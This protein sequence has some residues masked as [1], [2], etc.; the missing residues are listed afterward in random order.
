MYKCKYCGNYFEKGSIGG[1]TTFCVCNPNRKNNIKKN[2]DKDH[3]INMVKKRNEKRKNNPDIH[4]RKEIILK[5][6]KCGKE[7]TQVISEYNIQKGRYKKFCSAS[8]ANSHAGVCKGKTKIVKCIN[9][10]KNLEVKLNSSNKYAV[11]NECR[12]K[13]LNKINNSQLKSLLENKQRVCIICGKEFL[14]KITDSGKYSK[15]KYCSEECAKVDKIQNGYKAYEY[16]KSNGLHKPWQSRNIDSYPEKFWIKV[17]N[18]N[19]ISFKR[20]YHLDKKY[21]LDFYI[22]KGDIQIDLEIDGSQH[23]REDH[24]EHDQ[25]RDSYIKNKGI[26]IY[27]VPW[28]SINTKNGKILM[29]K[30]IDDFLEFYNKLQNN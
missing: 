12:Q 29:K 11:C 16:S 25:K 13:D 20:E 22:Q 3:I 2:S 9:C 26:L 7:F 18:N 8:C 17:L 5:C 19:D 27:R 4:T 14:P 24:I 21:F 6:E 10:G 30:K 15:S 1:H 23:L 28:N